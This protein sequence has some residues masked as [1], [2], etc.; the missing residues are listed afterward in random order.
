M[1]FNGLDIGDGHVIKVVK[2]EFNAKTD[3]SK[4]NNK[5]GSSGSGGADQLLSLEYG[6]T[7]G[8]GS[9]NGASGAG[10]DKPSTEQGFHNHF[11]HST[12]TKNDIGSRAT[13]AN[14]TPHTTATNANSANIAI[15]S[16]LYS[17]LPAETEAGVYP[18]ALILNA[19][20]P[21]NGHDDDP[22][23]FDELEV[24]CAVKFVVYFQHHFFT[25]FLSFRLA[26][27]RWNINPEPFHFFR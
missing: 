1:Q 24:C 26:L 13:N 16:I 3:A 14:T 4:T 12:S 23:Y 9:G 6:S 8:L 7:G 19:F 22:G 11:V 18:V 21:A 25:E 5:N 20:D 27:N 10:S 2:A 15:P 17:L